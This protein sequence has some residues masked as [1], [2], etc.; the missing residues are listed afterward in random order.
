M[1]SN[2]SPAGSSR[3]IHL[4][5]LDRHHR[6]LVLY[7]LIQA[8]AAM[9]VT[10]ASGLTRERI[11]L[12]LIDGQEVV[13]HSPVIVLLI[14]LLLMSAMTYALAGAT[15]G[16][17]WLRIPVAAIVSCL[18]LV[19][20]WGLGTLAWIAVPALLAFGYVLWRGFNPLPH[21]PGLKDLAII[22]AIVAAAWTLAVAFG[23]RPE[24]LGAIGSLYLGIAQLIAVASFLPMTLLLLSGLDLA[25]LSKVAAGK[26]SEACSRL[27]NRVVVLTLLLASAGKIA[28]YCWRGEWGSISS[29]L[30]MALF[31]AALIGLTVRAPRHA[32][33]FTP[34]FKHWL[35]LTGLVL[36]VPVGAIL[37]LIVGGGAIDT[38]AAGPLLLGSIGPLW[39]LF[40]AILAIRPGGRPFALFSA[41]LGSWALLSIG[42]APL[43]QLAFGS[44]VPG[45]GLRELDAG[46]AIFF[47]VWSV[48]LLVRGKSS[49]MAATALTATFFLSCG[50]VLDQLFNREVKVAEMYTVL[51]ALSYSIVRQLM[52][53][54]KKR[55]W[56]QILPWL[57]IIVMLVHSQLDSGIL[58]GVMQFIKISIITVAVVWDM[59]M[60]EDRLG[61]AEHLGPDRPARLL[62]YLGFV[63]WSVA[64]LVFAEG[65][66][67]A[68]ELE[69]EPLILF[70]FLIIGTPRVFHHFM[71]ELRSD[72]M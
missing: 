62:L 40:A 63:T 4:L 15:R 24:G 20:G 28:F 38:E 32:L 29:W 30:A 55:V 16:A 19:L 50:Y 21:H 2:P 46:T 70:G 36:T 58:D 9:I 60:S 11:S 14:A 65:G 56:L 7:G 59:L 37:I 33:E 54:T 64:Q 44:A 51:Q 57:I 10:Y 41:L 31:T 72:R 27:G 1:S 42:L 67:G 47:L 13:S 17:L 45:L 25:E 22:A 5:S 66:D 18:M 43:S 23:L 12:T 53:R 61:G 35:A 52:T 69:M 49:P 39:L 3:P 6:S 26:I 71:A 68:A 34:Q 48:M 8:A